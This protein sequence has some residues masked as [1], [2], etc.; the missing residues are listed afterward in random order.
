MLEQIPISLNLKV[1]NNF[2]VVSKENIYFHLDFSKKPMY[3]VTCLGYL[4]TWV[5]ETIIREARCEK[6][7]IKNVGSHGQEEVDTIIH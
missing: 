1:K 7:H 5:I 6:W 2:P 3:K 4:I